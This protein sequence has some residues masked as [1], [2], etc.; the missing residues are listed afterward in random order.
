MAS[1]DVSKAFDR[2]NHFALFVKLIGLGIPLYILNV[3]IN[4]HCK[5]LGCVR[6][7]GALS[8]VFAVKSGVRQGGILSPWLFNVYV[9]GLISRLRNSGVGC[10]IFYAFIGCIFFAD[11]MLLLSGSILH[12]QILLNICVDYGLDFDLTFNASKSF[13]IQFGLVNSNTLPVLSLG[14]GCL[15]WVERIKYLGVWLVEGKCFKVDCDVNRTKF[16][17]SVFGIMQRCSKV[18]EEILWNIISKCCLP[19]LL[20]GV[21]SLSLRVDQVHKLSVALNLAIR[22]CFHLAKNVSVRNLLYFVG[23]MPMK[24]LLDER[25]VK[26]VKSCFNGSEVL[27]LCARIRSADESFQEVCYMYDVH[28]EMSGDRVSQNFRNYLF[29]RLR[30]E[31]KL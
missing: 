23:C 11:D 22:R 10:Y 18:S 2:V 15:H 17:G 1:L 6:W 20:Y 13:L 14:A 3:L 21:D 26:L 9:N 5:L 4:W 25:I 27:R 8:G 30:D 19:T 29:L 7:L 31:G 28:C 12:L 16:L 24:M